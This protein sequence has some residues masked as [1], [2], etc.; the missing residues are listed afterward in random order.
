VVLAARGKPALEETASECSRPGA[1]TLVVP[2]DVRREP[3][4][5]ALAEAAVDR[6]GRFDVWVLDNGHFEQIPSESFRAVIETNLMGQ[7]HGS[8]AVLPHFRSQN[9]GTLINLAPIWA[10]VSTPDVSP[11]VTSKF[12]VRAFSGC[13]CQELADTPTIKVATMLPQAVDTPIFANS[14]NYS[15]PRPRPIPPMLTAE[16]VAHGIIIC[17]QSPKREVTQARGHP[18]A[19]SPGGGSAAQ[20]CCCTHCSPASTN[21][22][23]PVDLPPVTTPISRQRRPRET[24]SRRSC[25]KQ[26]HVVAEQHPLASACLVAMPL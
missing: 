12:A 5:Q 24:S 18:S 4:V 20:P 21:E 13:L 16:E 3:E 7:I 22:P 15:G 6:F 23:F 10:R 25:G 26:A 8:R 9:D 11:Y 17:A 14:G 19:R 2:T 1:E